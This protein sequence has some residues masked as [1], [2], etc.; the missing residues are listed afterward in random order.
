MRYRGMLRFDDLDG[1]V[2]PV[3]HSTSRVMDVVALLKRLYQYSR[4]DWTPEM[5]ILKNRVA[6]ARYR[7]IR[8]GKVGAIQEFLCLGVLWRAACSGLHCT[9]SVLTARRRLCEETSTTNFLS[10]SCKGSA[11]GISHQVVLELKKL[12][13]QENAVSV[14]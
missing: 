10:L 1:V 12:K 4:A 11:D 14:V 3:T 13:K 7:W 8:V 9:G 5:T 2:A 6:Y